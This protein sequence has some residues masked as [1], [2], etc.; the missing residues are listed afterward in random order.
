MRSFCY[1]F[2]S[3]ILMYSL[4]AHSSHVIGLQI[5]Y[6]PTGIGYSYIFRAKLYR[7]CMGLSAP[8]AVTID[9]SNGSCGG[10]IVSYSLPLVSITQV[11]LNACAGFGATTCQGGT[12]FGFEEVN[13]EGVVNGVSPCS[14]WVV[15]ATICCRNDAITNITNAATYSTYV[16]TRFDNLNF[17]GNRSP[18]FNAVPVSYYCVGIPS[19]KDYSAI[20]PDGDSLR[21]ELVPILTSYAAPIPFA[22]GYTYNQPLASFSNTYLDTLSGMLIFNPSQIQISSLAVKISEYRNGALIGSMMVD[23]EIIVATGM[24]NPDTISGRVYVDN[25]SNN[26]FD[27]GDLPVANT[28]VS[29]AP[30]NLVTSTLSNG[31]Y[32]LFVVDGIWNIT[33]PGPPPYFLVSP[34]GINVNTN[35]ITSSGGND[36][37]LTP[38][39]NIN[40][41]EVHLN[42]VGRPVPGQSYNLYVNYQNSGTTTQTGVD[43]TLTLDPLLQY[44]TAS[45][46]PTNVA[47]NTLIWT[48]PS[49]PVFGNGNIH[50]IT[51][52]DTTAIIGSP[53]N[54]VATVSSSAI[55]Y[56]PG[57]NTDI[58][59]EVVAAA[60]D[61]NIKEVAPSGDLPLSFISSQNWLTYKIH[62]Q[63]LGTAPAQVVRI[64]DLI[65]PDLQIST[66]EYLSSSFPCVVTLSSPNQVEFRFT[67]INLQPAS[68][69]EPASHG[70]VEFRIRPKSTLQPGTYITNNAGIYFDFA[71]PVYTNLVHSKVVT[72]VGFNDSPGDITSMTLY[73]NPATNQCKLEFNSPAAGN[74]KIDLYNFIGASVKQFTANVSSGMNQ[75]LFSVG[76]LPSGNYFMM[77]T[78]ENQTRYSRLSVVKE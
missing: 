33:L 43:V 42:D 24:A 66:L 19:L 60:Y 12:I 67:G 78:D 21:Y 4:P 9:L 57:N 64:V 1:L 45:P 74:I 30:G 44:V 69:N 36:F 77:I 13:Y 7:D 38:V 15:R 58:L 14:D 56:T 25:N 73:P 61:P 23:D 26:V 47:G 49:V 8:S 35:G 41:L 59:A 76:D 70:Y 37:I 16:E 51:G 40:D 3:L 72:S 27:G 5:S 53:V 28:T 6:E 34:S 20:D 11:P 2:A 50:I 17:P 39:S 63:N 46:A 48:I 31:K 32:E 71:T 65:D 75:I 18:Q 29:M 54:C 68:V 62:F 10:G 55:D 22:S 52:V